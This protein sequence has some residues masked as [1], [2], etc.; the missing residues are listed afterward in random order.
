M[1]IEEIIQGM[2]DAELIEVTKHLD[3]DVCDKENII[4][5]L[6]DSAS[7]SCSGITGFL[8]IVSTFAAIELGKRL[9]KLVNNKLI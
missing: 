7:D 9:E 4:R 6:K 3:D 8:F 5:K 1:R 2:S